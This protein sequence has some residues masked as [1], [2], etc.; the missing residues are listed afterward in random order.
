[1]RK[2]RSHF[3]SPIPTSV[4]SDGLR[5]IAL[6]RLLE[7][8]RQAEQ[9]R[10]AVPTLQ[11]D[12]GLVHVRPIDRI[13]W[14]VMPRW[15]ERAVAVRLRVWA[16][17]SIALITAGWPVLAT[18]QT[19]GAMAIRA[20]TVSPSG[21]SGSTVVVTIE[22]TATL[23]LPTA[24]VSGEPPR[25]FFD[26]PGVTLKAPAV[27]ESTD[28]RIRR[29]RAAINSVRP[30][31]TR[32]VIDLVA[33]QPYRVQSEA[34]RISVVVGEAGNEL[35]RGIPPVPSLQEPASPA[36]ASR[37]PVRSQPAEGMPAVMSVPREPAP[38]PAAPPV[39]A[40]PRPAPTEAPVRALPPAAEHSPVKPP[41]RAPSAVPARAAPALSASL[42]PG[43]DLE[44]Y[45]RQI[46]PALD[47]LRLQAPLLT[48]L[49]AA[50]DQTVDR[51]Q[52]AVEEFERLK[53]ELSGI[54]PPD[55]LRPQ[56]DMLLQST[57]LALIATRLRLEGFRTLDPATLR[58][59]ASAAAG[60]TL[61]LDR[62]CADLSCPDARR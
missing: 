57:I 18:A 17:L 16:A 62:V 20:I 58:N 13:R 50:E 3:D 27:T 29:I 6:S 4:D 47:R 35:A 12:T 36:P 11:N 45:R 54:K 15:R 59:A 42:P 53:Q 40:P 46:S 39:T 9:T 22:G 33:L 8:N 38:S 44:R 30:L 28:P 48:S 60:A 23:P 61:L 52:L 25:I 41:A 51:V 55:S 56:H 14:R 7:Q 1:M 43:K 5:P 31:V 26:F 24:G 37:E 19:A 10:I 2:G 32:V 34:G 49:D 21:T